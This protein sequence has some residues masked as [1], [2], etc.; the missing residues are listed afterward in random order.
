MEI[1]NGRKT[2]I[3]KDRWIPGMPNPPSPQNDLFR[4]YEF[5]EELMIPEAAQWNIQLINSLFDPDTTLK[6]QT[7]YINENNEDSMIWMPAKDGIFSVK[8]TYKM[9]TYNNREVQVEGRTIDRKVWKTLW[10]CKAAQRI[11]IFAW[12]SIRGL[13]STKYKRAMFNSSLEVNCDICGCNEET[14]EHILFEC[15]HAREVWRGININIDSVRASSNTVSEWVTS[16]FSVH[17]QNK[18]ERWL[19]SLMIGAWI[20]W[21][22][23]CDVVFQG[24]SLNPCTTIHRIHYHLTSH[25]HKPHN[26]ALM[27]SQSSRWKPP[28]ENILKYNIDGSFDLDTNQFGTGIVVC[29]FAGH[30]IGTKRTYGNRALNLEAVECM[31]IHEALLWEKSLNHSRIHI[32]AG[33]KLVIQS[34]NVHTLLIQWENRN[35][36]KEIK[37]LSSKFN[38]C[39]FDY[40]NKDDNQVADALARSPRETT[41]STE[42]FSDFDYTICDLLAGD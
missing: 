17:N 8:S 11:K 14:I 6:I 16:W 22:D 36:I 42:Y 20:I 7:L 27:N 33:A 18:E 32:E 24:V 19:F 9:L 1:N 2:K 12:K 28:L 15:R 10:S 34:I 26:A 35:L 37:H 30:C 31:A 5:V 23:H 29:D 4:F 41:I 3:R 38:L 21:K 39:T 40:V 13:H 25:M